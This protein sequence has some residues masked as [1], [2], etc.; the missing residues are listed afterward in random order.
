MPSNKRC[1]ALVVISLS[2]TVLQTYFLACRDFSV[3]LSCCPPQVRLSKELLKKDKDIEDLMSR[4]HISVSDLF[5]YISRIK[6][7]V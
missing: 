2:V 6:Q 5:G 1:Y 7:F 4:G 3:M